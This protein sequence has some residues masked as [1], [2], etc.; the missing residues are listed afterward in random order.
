MVVL[1]AA[2]IEGGARKQ[3]RSAVHRTS[4]EIAVLAAVA[5]LSAACSG[6]GGAKSAGTDMDAASPSAPVADG[7]VSAPD[8]EGGAGDSTLADADAGGAPAQDGGEPADSGEGGNEAGAP[9]DAGSAENDASG[10]SGGSCPAPVVGSCTSIANVG[11]SVIITCPGGSPPPMIGGAIAEGTYVLAGLAYYGPNTGDG[12]PCGL[13]GPA[14]T[15]LFSSGCSQE[16]TTASN[17]P[18]ASSATYATSGNQLTLTPVCPS[19]HAPVTYPYT[20]TSTS[21]VLNAQPTAGSVV[22]TTLQKQ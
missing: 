6:A 7:S 19:A 17:A 16:I 13:I 1:V 8:V 20:A 11:A 10:G 2:S 15:F 12:G 22:I 14:E 5:G 21:I 9:K 18:P 4:L 3:G